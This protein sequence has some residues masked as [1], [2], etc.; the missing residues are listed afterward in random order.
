MKQKAVKQKP[1]DLDA[2]CARLTHTD[3]FDAAFRALKQRDDPGLYAELLS[4]A[5]W[6]DFVR[7]DLEVT[8]FGKLQ[9]GP[10]LLRSAT[11]GGMHRGALNG[12]LL[13]LTARAEGPIAEALRAQVLSLQ[14]NHWGWEGNTDLQRLAAFPNLNALRLVGCRVASPMP[15]LR[16]RTLDVQANIGIDDDWINAAAPLNLRTDS[17]TAPRSVVRL[18]M[19]ATQQPSRTHIVGYP[20]LVELTLRGRADLVVRDCPRLRVVRAYEHAGRVVFSAW[21]A[22]PNLEVLEIRSEPTVNDDPA[23]LHLP[24]LPALRDL[25]LTGHPVD[26]ANVPVTV[27]RLEA[28]LTDCSTLNHL[29]RPTELHIAHP[30]GRGGWPRVLNASAL[31]TLDLSGRVLVDADLL[32]VHESPDL[33]RLHLADTGIACL[34]ALKS[35]AGIALLDLS[36]CANLGDVSALSSL[37]AL[38]VTR[39]ARRCGI[40]VHELP[41]A[42]QWTANGQL[43]PD[44]QA[45]LQRTPPKLSPRTLPSG[46]P[47]S[48]QRLVDKVFPLL[49]RRS[50]EAIDVAVDAI[51]EAD[52][53][54][55][56][57]YWLDGLQS[58]NSQTKTICPRRF[59]QAVPDRAFVLHATLRLIGTAPASCAAAEPLRRATALKLDFG[60]LAAK[61]HSFDLSLLAGLVELESV[62]LSSMHIVMPDSPR[63]D[64]LPRLTSLHVSNPRPAPAESPDSRSGPS[65]K[66]LLHEQLCRTLPHVCDVQVR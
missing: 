4:G 45:L 10:R 7:E 46:L 63:P 20:D 39:I 43:N 56:W 52:I 25:T 31:L 28:P 26:L 1:D 27:R 23:T 48:A 57:D 9:P 35:H 53:P 49:Q 11:H 34:D 38:R 62:W 47:R 66:Q 18:E 58:W 15:V 22:L 42:Q 60:Y 64:W 17:G 33:Q 41:V 21:S 14:F 50:F 2:L 16:L 8:G 6:S 54:K 37:P 12:L 44:L 32:R 5:G 61:V 40:N 30:G 36:G 65:P 3:T 59:S 51:S 29:Q 19:N 13:F 55:V 24:D